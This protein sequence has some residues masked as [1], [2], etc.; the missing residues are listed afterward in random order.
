MTTSPIQTVNQSVSD[1][2]TAASNTAR[3]STSATTT[4][5]AVT[6]GKT[7]A[8][9]FDQFLN[10]LT[11]QLRNQSPLD[12]LDTNQFT[13][14]LVQ[15]SQVEQQLKTNDQLS[16]ILTAVKGNTK[17]LDPAAASGLLGKVAT[18]DT[19]VA[20][21]GTTGGAW[22]FEAEKDAA[23]ATVTVTDEAGNV[24]YT[25]TGALKAGL[26]VYNWNGLRPDGTRV[27]AGSYTLNVNAKDAAG[28][29]VTIRTERSGVVNAV[30][31]SGTEEFVRVG[32]QTIPLTRIR[33][34]AAPS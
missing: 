34:V 22:S 5:A 1:R 20:R 24:V 26:Q 21:V 25:Q 2:V 9:N 15:F 16:A 7:L 3:S 29:A 8:S 28:N 6:D 10:L 19:S 23:A 17:K 11:T 32:D 14:Q 33:T 31:V 13:Q 4:S 12:P 27:P 18:Y 30:D